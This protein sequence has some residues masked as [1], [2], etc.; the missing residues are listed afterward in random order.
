MEYEGGNDNDIEAGI[1]TP[2]K[3]NGD[4]RD[5]ECLELLDECDIVVTNPPFSNQL[6]TQLIKLCI[7][8]K[9]FTYN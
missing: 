8:K 2:L 5:E 1:K 7:Q 3:G 4:F 9:K 6:P